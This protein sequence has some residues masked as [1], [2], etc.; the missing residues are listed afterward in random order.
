MDTLGQWT[1]RVEGETK[2]NFHRYVESPQD[3]NNSLAYYRMGML[4]TVLAEDLRIRYTPQLEEKLLS[5]TNANLTVE[6]WNDF[7][8]NPG[9]V[10]LHGLLSGSHVGTCSSMPFVYV[11]IGRRLGYPVTIAARKHHLYVRYDDGAGK[12]LNVESTEN[13]G[14]ATPTDEEYRNGP[15]PMTEEE[16][17][18]A[19]WLRPL[20]VGASLDLYH[21]YDQ[22]A[23]PPN[24]PGAG[25]Q[26]SMSGECTCTVRK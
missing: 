9:D 24:S 21:G 2:R 26:E 8:S 22:I 23:S 15:F 25:W 12:H 17:R 4:G 14:F 1:R 10:F 20:T 7:F 11:S 19:G 3:Y 6:D 5:Q 18:D 13:L 16:I